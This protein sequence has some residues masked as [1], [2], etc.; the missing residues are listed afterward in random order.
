MRVFSSNLTG[1]DAAYFVERNAVKK[2]IA[3]LL[4]SAR[5]FQPY[6]FSDKLLSQD[7]SAA[8]KLTESEFLSVSL[9]HLAMRQTALFD[10]NFQVYT[11]RCKPSD[12]NC[13]LESSSSFFYKKSA[14][15]PCIKKKF[16]RL[17]FARVFDCTHN[18]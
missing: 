12:N 5:L 3:P 17:F 8:K 15:P 13:E 11:F 7:Y 6:A 10:F 2:R 4:N 16:R 1:P 9:K 14:L 18:S